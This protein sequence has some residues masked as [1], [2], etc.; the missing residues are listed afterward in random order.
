[1]ANYKIYTRSKSV[2]SIEN[3]EACYPKEAVERFLKEKGFFANILKGTKND[4]NCRVQDLNTSKY[5]YYK[6]TEMVTLE[7][8]RLI[9]N[10]IAA[11]QRDG[12][13]QVIYK[14]KEGFSFI[15]DYP[16]NLLYDKVQVLGKV[17][18]SYQKGIQQAKYVPYFD[19]YTN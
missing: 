11:A 7:L 8:H 4:S 1:M 6:I 10:A 19:N 14:D 15:R 3:I 18:L 16:N 17:V 5:F 13:D 12:Y 2:G 9:Q